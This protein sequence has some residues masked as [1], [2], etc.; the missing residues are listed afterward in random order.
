LTYRF[1]AAVSTLLDAFVYP[2]PETACYAACN[3]RKRLLVGPGFCLLES[4]KPEKARSYWVKSFTEGDIRE[5]MGTSPR[6]PGIGPSSRLHALPPCSRNRLEASVW[7]G[8][9]P[10]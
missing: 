7:L 3:G 1:V 2:P 10:S 8:G 5:I 9:M 6:T 4:V